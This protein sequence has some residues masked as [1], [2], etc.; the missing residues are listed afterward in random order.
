MAVKYLDATVAKN[1]DVTA[2]K[3]SDA[4]AVKSGRNGDEIFR[5]DDGKNPG[6]D[7]GKGGKN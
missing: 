5:C 4:T 6:C 7:S 1:S 3:Y 2:V